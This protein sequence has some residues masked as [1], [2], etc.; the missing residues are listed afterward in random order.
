MFFSIE[1][2]N[3]NGDFMIQTLLS[4]MASLCHTH[5]FVYEPTHGVLFLSDSLLEEF[6]LHAQENDWDSWMKITYPKDL[7]SLQD[8]ICIL[9][10]QKH[11]SLFIRCYSRCGKIIPLTFQ[12]QRIQLQKQTCIAGTKWSSSVRQTSGGRCRTY[13]SITTC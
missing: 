3:K 6:H 7:K 10:H 11:A 9:P 2:H 13:I 5:Y 1:A 4:L 12:T 8:F